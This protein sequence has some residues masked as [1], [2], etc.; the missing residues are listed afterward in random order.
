MKWKTI[1]IG[2][3]I[4][5]LLA[6]GFLFYFLYLESPSRQV[7]AQVN[8]EKIT[9]EQFNKELEKLQ[10]PFKEMAKEDPQSFLENIVVQRLLLQEAKKQGLTRSGEDL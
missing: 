7:L 5:I 3:V 2:A 6:A 4:F 1:I 8:G 9:L 10:S